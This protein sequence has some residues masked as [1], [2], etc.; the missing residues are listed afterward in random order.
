MAW[1]DHWIPWRCT[2]NHIYN[3][4]LIVVIFNPESHHSIFFTLPLGSVTLAKPEFWDSVIFILFVM[5]SVLLHQTEESCSCFINPANSKMWNDLA[6]V[7]ESC[8]PIRVLWH[9]LISLGKEMAQPALPVNAASF[10]I[11]PTSFPPFPSVFRWT[12]ADGFI[13]SPMN[14]YSVVLQFV[15]TWELSH[16]CFISCDS[17]ACKLRTAPRPCSANAVQAGRGIFVCSANWRWNRA[18]AEAVEND[19]WHCIAC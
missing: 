15:F 19:H 8:P 12:A 16:Q 10:A 6:G 2:G 11:R 5:A 7:G 3:A 9:A 18:D 17:N 13:V 14:I 1:A 4:K